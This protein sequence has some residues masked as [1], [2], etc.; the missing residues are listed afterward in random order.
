MYN[1]NK[2]DNYIIF[3]LTEWVCLE[4]SFG[5]SFGV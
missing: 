2:E 3:T 1:F 4:F 5:V